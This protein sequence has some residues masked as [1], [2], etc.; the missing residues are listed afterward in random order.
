MKITHFTEE[1]TNDVL[2]G[3]RLLSKEE[4]EFLIKDTPSFEEC[5]EKPEELEKLGDCELMRACYRT[6]A[7]YASGQI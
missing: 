7:D 2:D 5:L 1:L 6:W 3:V 4:R